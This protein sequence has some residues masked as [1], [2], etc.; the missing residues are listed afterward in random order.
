MITQSAVTVIAPVP[1]DREDAL[2]QLLEQAG[3]DAAHNS[4]A[5]FARLTNVHFARFFLLPGDQRFATQLVFLAD[6]DGPAEPFLES[7]TT[8]LGDGLD[9]IYQHTQGYPGRAH[10]LEFLKR[11]SLPPA[12]KY[13]NTIGRTVQQIRQEAELHDALEEFLDRNADQWRGASAQ[14]VRAAIQECVRTEPRL[15]WARQPA[16]PSEP[17]YALGEVLHL[18]LIGIAVTVLMPVILP[19]LPVW[20]FFLRRHEKSDVARDVIPTDDWRAALTAQEDHGVQNPYTSAGFVK[21]GPFRRFTGTLV[22]WGTN[23]LT[24]HFFNHAD[25]IGVKTIHFGRWVFLDQKRRLFFASN[26]DGSLE[27][28]MDDFVD[29]IAWALNT[30]F[31]SGVDYPQTNWLIKDGAHD[32]QTFKRFNIMHQLVTPFW[33]AAYQGLSALN[34]D[35]NAA[36]RAGLYGDMDEVAVRAWLRRLG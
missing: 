20:A 36:I 3:A 22:L 2:R 13:V 27:N 10:L 34:I 11:R 18:A 15:A 30:A 6:V 9:T 21:P 4:L 28:Y 23:V 26:Y 29:K 24:R 35:N 32:E 19:A 31:S 7:M 8:L 14:Q 17:S 16:P 5:P 25:L 12:A 1:A 33:Y